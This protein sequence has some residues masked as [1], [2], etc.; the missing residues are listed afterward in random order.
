MR[1]ESMSGAG[2]PVT[3]ERVDASLRLRRPEIEVETDAR[4]AV[5]DE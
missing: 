4:A 1:L 2:G 5:L 3:A